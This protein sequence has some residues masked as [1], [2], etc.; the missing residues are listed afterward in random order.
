[1]KTA[2]KKNAEIR[3]LEEELQK[4][5]GTKIEINAKGKGRAIKGA[6]KV[7]FY[8]LEDLERLI[9]ILKKKSRPN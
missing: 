9:E 4:I 7:S 5:L 8:S 1:M 2:A 3:A 6:V